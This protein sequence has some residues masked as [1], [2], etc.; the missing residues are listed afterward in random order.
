LAVIPG[1]YDYE[2]RGIE[3][4]DL[5]RYPDDV[6]RLYWSWVVEIGLTIKAKE[7]LAGIDVTGTTM[8]IAAKTRKRRK[9]AMTASGKGDPAAPALIPGWQKSRTYSLLAGKPFVDHAEF[10]WRYDP[11]TGKQW[12]VTLRHLAD[13][14][15][16]T[17]GLSPDGQA[18]L[19]VQSWAY[20]SKYKAGKLPERLTK[21]PGPPVRAPV[22][23]PRVG[24][25]ERTYVTPGG[26]VLGAPGKGKIETT[27]LMTPEEWRQF[28]VGPARAAPPGRPVSPPSRSPIS[29]PGYQRIIAYTW[30]QGPRRGPG[31]LAAAGA[32]PGPRKPTFGPTAAKVSIK[33]SQRIVDAAM[34]ATFGRTIDTQELASLTGATSTARVD[35][36]AGK[37]PIGYSIMLDINDKKYGSI[38]TIKRDIFGKL[39]L[40]ANSLEVKKDF[41]GQGIGRE[42]FGRMVETATRLGVDRIETAAMRASDRNGYYTWPLFGYDG[43]IPG[44]IREILPDWLQGVKRVSEIM[45]TPEGQQWWKT[46]GVSVTLR[47]DLAPGSYSRQ[48]WERYLQAKAAQS[49]KVRATTLTSAK[50]T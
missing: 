28:F 29:G 8:S 24:R 41:Q 34:K 46:N 15:L 5:A 22:E 6:R 26:M 20:W 39:I 3:P 4:A 19:K 31:P 35:V 45:A 9:S 23:I 27:G 47:F 1:Q 11:W 44:A 7:I 30:P 33:T 40:E 21:L 2:I 36:Y 37:T 49:Q 13:R 17:I 38:R 25:Y 43:E 14:G 48:T 10:Y 42:I 16:D 32:A 18:S 50:A 12:G